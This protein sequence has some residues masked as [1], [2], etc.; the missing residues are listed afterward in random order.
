MSDPPPVWTEAV[1]QGLGLIDNA[2]D[3]ALPSGQG[4]I[5]LMHEADIYA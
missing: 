1:I 3:G 4:H 5:H 2:A